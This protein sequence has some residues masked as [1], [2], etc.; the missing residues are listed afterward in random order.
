MTGPA[1]GGV[2]GTGGGGPRTTPR[3]SPRLPGYP[4]RAAHAAPRRLRRRR[5]DAQLDPEGQALRPAGARRPVRGHRPRTRSR[6]SRPTPS[7]RLNGVVDADTRDGARQRDARAGRDLVRPR[8]LRQP[9]RLRPDAHPT[10]GGRRP[11]DASLR[12]KVV[13]RYKRPLRAARTVIDRGPYANGAKPGISPRRPRAGASLHRDRRA[14]G[15]EARRPRGRARRRS[16]LG[17]VGSTAESDWSW[18]SA[19]AFAIR[20]W[21]SFIASCATASSSCSSVQ[22]SSRASS[23]RC[24]A[25]RPSVSS[26]A[27]RKASS[28]A[29]LL[30]AGLEAARARRS[31]RGRGPA[32]RAVLACWAIE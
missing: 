29:S 9:D 17:R 11:Q 28:A 24:W 18:G 7:C 26:S 10:D 23:P 14:P 30:V 25:G 32:A 13:L 8:L 15:R 21:N 16:E 2:G 27:S 19:A 12:S 31:R 1:L 22:P 3:T 5:R 4:A 20:L 6:R